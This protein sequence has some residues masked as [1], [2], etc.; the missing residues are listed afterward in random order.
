MSILQMPKKKKIK[1]QERKAENLYTLERETVLLYS[2]ENLYAL[3]TVLLQ[4]NQRTFIHE[5]TFVHDRTSEQ[6]RGRGERYCSGDR[7]L[8]RITGGA[9][10]PEVP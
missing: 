8:M 10:E 1:K 3:K 6:G 9:A 7:A 2:K 5:R 4:S